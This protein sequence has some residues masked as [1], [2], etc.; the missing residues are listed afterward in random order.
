MILS[1]IAGI[2]THN[3]LGGKN[4][5]LW[6]L[7]N[8][9][10]YF[11]TTTKGHPIIMG[12]KTF[13]SIGRALPHRRNIVVTRDESYSAEGIECASSLEKALEL[14]KESD[15]EVFLIGGGELYKQAL[16]FADKLYITHIDTASLE[17]ALV[18]D[19]FFPQ[20]GPE[21]KEISRE[22]HAPDAEHAYGY[23]FVVYS[24]D[25]AINEI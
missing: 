13:E 7:P 10:Q 11:R 14:F 4:Q 5:L 23:S 24:H 16:P 1:L 2:G 25:K 12:R 21:W 19:T 17:T 18:A 20:I 3:E 15:E 8:D 9:M 6:H 22:D